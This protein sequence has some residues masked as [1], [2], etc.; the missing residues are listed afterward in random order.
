MSAAAEN[1]KPKWEKPKSD[2]VENMRN[3]SGFE[4]LEDQLGQS[5]VV[6]LRMLNNHAGYAHEMNDPLVKAH[7][8]AIDFARSNGN[9]EQYIEHDI[10]MMLPINTRIKNV[11]EKTGKP[12]VAM[13]A[14]FDRTACHYALALDTTGDGPARTWKSPFT[15]VLTACQKIGQFPDLSE[16]WIHENWTKPRLEAYGRDMGINIKVSSLAAD[17]TITAELAE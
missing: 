12:E 17:G 11:V 10:K 4:G 7:L 3:L 15:I 6:L 16:E 1:T 9:L 5:I 2:V 14:L 13:A 8:M